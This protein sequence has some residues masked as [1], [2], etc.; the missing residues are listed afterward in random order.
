MPPEIIFCE[1]PDDVAD[2]AADLIFHDQAAAIEERGIY[3]IALSGG[4]TPKLLYERLTSEDWRSEMNWEN[5]EVF[6]SDERAVPPDHPDSNFRLAEE[7]LLLHVP[8]GNVWRMHGEMPDLREA[9]DDYARTLRLRFGLKLP[10][11]DTILLGMGADG[12]TAS[13]FPG[14]PALESAAL[15]ETVEISSQTPPRR[16]TLTLP[17]LNHALRVIF[18]VVGDEKAERVSDIFQHEDASL[19]AARVQPEEGECAWLLDHA[20]ADLI[21]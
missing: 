10:V 5:W 13:L 17:V 8:V 11:F 16:L 15:V 2:A 18:L 12:H 4:H 7:A 14:H 20:A 19:P 1:T 6:W 21:R 3:R 9:A